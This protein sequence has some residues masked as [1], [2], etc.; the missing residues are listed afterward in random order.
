MLPSRSS[1]QRSTGASYVEAAIAVPLFLLFVF[2]L[3]DF[4]RYFLVS[5]ML[6]WAAQSGADWASKVEVEVITTQM[7]DG[8]DPCDSRGCPG[9]SGTRDNCVFYENLFGLITQ[10]VLQDVAT[11]TAPSSADS[12]SSLVQW[13]HYH[14]QD[15][16]CNPEEGTYGSG[17]DSAA[18]WRTLDVAFLRPG[19]RVREVGANSERIV[20][21]PMRPCSSTPGAVC[22]TGDNT[23]WPRPGE[24]WGQ[25]LEANPVVVLLEVR[26]RPITPLM[27][28][29]RIQSMQFGF[30][31][32]RQFGVGNPS[33]PLP[34]ATNAPTNTPTPVP[35]STNTV[36]L[37]PTATATSTTTMTPTETATATSSP[38]ITQTPTRTSTPTITN[39]P[40]ET[41]TPTQTGTPT[42]TRTATPTRTPTRTPTITQTPTITPTPTASGTA[43][44]TPTPTNTA[45]ITMT[46]TITQTPTIT[47]TPTI[48]N[49][50]ANTP[51]GT[52][53][54]TRT[55]TR[56][57]TPINTPTQTRTP[58]RTAT[59]TRTPTVTNTPTPLCYSQCGSRTCA[60]VIPPRC[61]NAL[62]ADY[63][64]CTCCALNGLCSGSCP[65]PPVGG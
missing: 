65:A 27:P 47:L 59:P 36:F 31:T 52:N 13:E 8:E 6:N 21:H 53:T 49:T 26:F 55:P 57:P 45:T 19:E 4:A 63:N 22:Q 23:G 40:T 41:G 10:R 1:R 16:V 12:Y 11:F 30:R 17:L 58:T 43:T 9:P 51:T 35:T 39:T 60:E 37:S 56:T 44:I 34:T 50:P 14:P 32:T 48:T 33:A 3:I 64:C 46:P 62:P 24:S 20:E 38:T 29:L 7:A 2:A 54:P 42:N 25:I 15:Y 5:G 28:E 18:G 61:D